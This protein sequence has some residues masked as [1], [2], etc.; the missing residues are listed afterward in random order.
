MEALQSTITTMKANQEFVSQ[1][2]LTIEILEKQISQLKHKRN[3]AIATIAR[4]K[5]NA[6]TDIGHLPK[7]EQ[8]Q[9]LEMIK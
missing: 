1:S 8:A 6:L 5:S 9:Y 3:Q 4:C 7:E 2:E